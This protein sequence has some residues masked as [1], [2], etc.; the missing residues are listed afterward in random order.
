LTAVHTTCT[1]RHATPCNSKDVSAASLCLQL[2]TTGNKRKQTLVH[3][4][5]AQQA[6]EH[7]RTPT[8]APRGT[9]QTTAA[10]SS[11]WP[12]CPAS[13]STPSSP[14][15][16]TCRPHQQR[17]RARR[18]SSLGPPADM[19][20]KSTWWH[21]SMGYSAQKVS[22]Q[23]ASK[24]RQRAR[25]EEEEEGWGRALN[26]I[27]RAPYLLR[28]A[29]VVVAVPTARAASS[30]VKAVASGGTEEAL[31]CKKGLGPI[32]CPNPANDTRNKRPTSHTQEVVRRTGLGKGWTEKAST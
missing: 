19:Q 14:Q 22:I 6:A 2:W 17:G 32:S 4:Q 8:Q 21:G 13:S 31:P 15:W 1:G 27:D 20:K 9:G 18:G 24:A 3:Q 10:A 29:C 11:P 7:K 12:S 25:Q 16:A 23:R 26:V 5:R 28:V 30:M